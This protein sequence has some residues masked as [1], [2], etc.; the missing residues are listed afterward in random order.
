MQ[1][2]SGVVNGHLCLPLRRPGFKY[3]QKQHFFLLWERTIKS[4]YAVFWKGWFF[5]NQ[6]DG[7]EASFGEIV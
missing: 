3:R 1:E 5:T 2:G 7:A 6:E 4:H